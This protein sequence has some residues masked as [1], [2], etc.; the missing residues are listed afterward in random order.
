MLAPDHYQLSVS[1]NPE[2]VPAL[3]DGDPGSRWTGPQRGDTW[4]DVQLRRARPVAGVKLR[5]P[6]YA[7]GD[8]PHHLRV[9]GT[10]QAGAD[11]V[12]FDEAGVTATALTSVF[13]PAEPGLRITWPP[14]VLSRLRL[15][16]RG[17][18]GDRQWSVFELQVLDGD[19]ELVDSGA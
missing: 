8:Y 11:V 12:L 7:I 6:A 17:V 19:S 16:Q 9:V 18:A 10:D 14:T 15:E 1:H 5:L 3:V 2:Q 13:E 4:L